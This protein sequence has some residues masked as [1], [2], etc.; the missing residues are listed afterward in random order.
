M[1]RTQKQRKN[2]PFGER[3]DYAC[4]RAA[5][6]RAWQAI[7]RSQATMVGVDQEKSEDDVS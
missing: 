2:S 5:K 7:L 6:P 4:L 3:T 1:L